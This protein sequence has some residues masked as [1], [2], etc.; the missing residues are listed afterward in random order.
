MH[1]LARRR[2]IREL[3]VLAAYEDGEVHLGSLERWR[4]LEHEA[5]WALSA[6]LYEQDRLDR[7]K[8]SAQSEKLRQWERM[9]QEL[10]D[11]FYSLATQRSL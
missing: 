4:E 1:P 5:A 10:E 7:L 8:W 3:A 2:L 11:V 6:E 9:W